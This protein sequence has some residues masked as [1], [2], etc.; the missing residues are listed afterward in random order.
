M[1]WELQLFMNGLQQQK[2]N[3]SISSLRLSKLQQLEQ[4]DE[5]LRVNFNCLLG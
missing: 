3:N 5:T 4:M 1:P 2:A